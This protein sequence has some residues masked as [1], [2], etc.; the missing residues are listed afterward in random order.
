MKKGAD[1]KEPSLPLKQADLFHFISSS[2]LIYIVGGASAPPGNQVSQEQHVTQS[3]KPGDRKIC[4]T[5]LRS[6]ETAVWVK[7]AFPKSEVYY[8]YMLL[9]FITLTAE[10]HFN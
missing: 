3:F 6:V 1:F 9:P 5:K 7:P 10:S 4:S 2:V 8:K